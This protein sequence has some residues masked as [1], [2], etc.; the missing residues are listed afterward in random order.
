[1]GGRKGG[2]KER[3]KEGTKMEGSRKGGRKE[4]ENKKESLVPVTLT[5]L[6]GCTLKL[7]K[8][9]VPVPGKRGSENKNRKGQTSFF[10]LQWQHLCDAIILH[11]SAP[12]SPS[13]LSG[14]ENKGNKGGQA[15][16]H[17]MCTGKGQ[18]MI[19][20]SLTRDKSRT[21]KIRVQRRQ[22]S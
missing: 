16:L 10:T 22:V 15:C 11:C 20:F 3:R 14:P 12:E 9:L 19:R 13:P 6:P 18:I 2:K 17:V 4:R 21:R 7:T 5:E 1:M 8:H